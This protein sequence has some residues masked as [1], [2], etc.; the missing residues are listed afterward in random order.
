[1]NPGRLLLLLT[2]L[3]ATSSCKRSDARGLQV[4]A[5][6]SL[7]D[8]FRALKRGF[9]QRHPQIPVS[10]VFA[11]S[12]VLRLQLLQ[13]ANA[14]VFAS[15]NGHHMKALQRAR[16]IRDVTTFAHNR[17]ALIVPQDNPAKLRS[18]RDLPRA[19]RLV[20]GTPNV[21]I[22]AYTQQLLARAA[23]RW[24]ADFRAKTLSRVVSQ[25]HHVRMVRAKVMLGEADAAIVYETDARGATGIKRIPIPAALNVRAAYPIGIIAATRRRNQATKWLRY[26]RSPQGRGIL[27]HHGFALP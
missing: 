6:A 3:L 19:R 21:P 27:Q 20:V 2:A 4:Y 14:D 26:L 10:L 11:G 23:A 9:V 8:V 15:A 5:A 16:L 22:G 12:Q 25:E 18:L 24:G 17:L 1:M 13:G 7:T